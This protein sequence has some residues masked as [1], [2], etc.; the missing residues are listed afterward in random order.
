M[1]KNGT[2]TVASRADFGALK[3]TLAHLF[4]GAADRALARAIDTLR[5]DT[6]A[7][8]PYSG[9]ARSTPGNPAP[10][11]D[12]NHRDS[13]VKYIEDQADKH[14]KADR[15][16][17]GTVLRALGGSL[18]AHLDIEPGRGEIASSVDAVIRATVIAF[19]RD[20]PPE[21]K[22]A[23]ILADNRKADVCRLRFAA[24]WIASKRLNGWAAE[25]VAAG[26]RRDQKT[27]KHGL[28]RAEEYRERDVE[29]CAV[30]DRLS[31]MA[32]RCEHCLTPLENC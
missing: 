27:F 28:D 30:T 24:M 22:I 9:P 20:T 26:F 13:I 21:L 15:R 1:S 32:I 14:D 4:K 31:A 16:E 19:E 25:R 18:I 23:E 3:G 29:F 7:F 6:V 17:I 2:I 11:N 12:F 10:H 5:R 8:M